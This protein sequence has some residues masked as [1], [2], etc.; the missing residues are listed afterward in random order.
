MAALAVNFSR[1]FER[2]RRA[3]G[4]KSFLRR[5]AENVERMHQKSL[6]EDFIKFASSKRVGVNEGNMTEKVQ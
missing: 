5:E 4:E 6:K 2:S 1:L 3:R